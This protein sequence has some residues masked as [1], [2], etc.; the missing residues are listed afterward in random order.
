MHVFLQLVPWVPLLVMLTV[1][2]WSSRDFFSSVNGRR[3]HHFSTHD[4]STSFFFHTKTLLTAPAFLAPYSLSEYGSLLCSL[5]GSVTYVQL[6]SD[7][8]T[9]LQ[10]SLSVKYGGLGFHSVGCSWHLPVFFPLPLLHSVDPP[11]LN[12]SLRVYNRFLYCIRMKLYLSCWSA[13][14]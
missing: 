5:L 13:R 14:I 1:L 3:L 7:S 2:T 10:A 11:S 6:S 9:W 8:L 12:Y 4:A